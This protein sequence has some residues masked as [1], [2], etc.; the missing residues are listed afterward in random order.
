ML[1][2]RAMHWVTCSMGAQG[3][4]GIRGVSRAGGAGEEGEPPGQLGARLEL[5]E[6]QLEEVSQLAQ[7][8][9]CGC[10]GGW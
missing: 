10:V 5:M 3:K 6:K 2:V 9:L 4:R 1:G 8:C 7:P